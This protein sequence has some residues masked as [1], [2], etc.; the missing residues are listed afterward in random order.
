ML[1]PLLCRV[2]HLS[3]VYLGRRSRTKSD[4]SIKMYEE[5]IQVRNGRNYPAYHDS[6]LVCR[7]LLTCFYALLLQEWYAEYSRENLPE[8]DQSLELEP[9]SPA[10]DMSS[11]PE[12][13]LNSQTG[14]H[15]IN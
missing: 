3:L 4:L 2:Q 7:N 10:P 13:Q 12:P 9:E 5:E 11:C 1:S 6:S 8:S 14:P 15:S